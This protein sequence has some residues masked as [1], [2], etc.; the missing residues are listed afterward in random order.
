MWTEDWVE[1]SE[2]LDRMTGRFQVV[3]QRLEPTPPFARS[4]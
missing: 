3:L 4:A 1:T 2:A